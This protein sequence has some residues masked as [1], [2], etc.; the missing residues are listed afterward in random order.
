MDPMHDAPLVPSMRVAA[1][2]SRNGIFDEL[3]TSLNK[4]ALCLVI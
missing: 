1:Q 2:I 4:H 3:S